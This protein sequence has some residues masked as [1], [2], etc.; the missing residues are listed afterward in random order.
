MRLSSPESPE[1]ES[2][3]NYALLP[4]IALDPTMESYANLNLSATPERPKWWQ[5]RWN[6]GLLAPYKSPNLS[7]VDIDS[8][9]KQ[10]PQTYVPPDDDR[11][12]RLT[13]GTALYTELF[14]G[15]PLRTSGDEWWN[16]DHNLAFEAPY[17]QMPDRMTLF[18]ATRANPMAYVEE[19]SEHQFEGY[20]I[21][22]TSMPTSGADWL[23]KISHRLNP[24]DVGYPLAIGA[25]R[26]AETGG[27]APSYAV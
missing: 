10:R 13:P 18:A 20:E 4:G 24:D 23:M 16:T 15:P 21:Y 12:P 17:R 26:R 11:S 5:T 25:Y 22:P 6:M 9:P 7:R 8:L 2:P 27:E 19:V 14:D 3:I 1:L